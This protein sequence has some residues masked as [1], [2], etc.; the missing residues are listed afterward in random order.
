MSQAT[1]QATVSYKGYTA[2]VEW[3]DEECRFVGDSVG[4]VNTLIEVR[5]ATLEDALADFAD[6]IEW[7]IEGC[8]SEGI[9]PEKP[10]VLR[11]PDYS[12]GVPQMG[13]SPDEVRACLSAP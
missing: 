1:A 8:K 5:G 13:L 12:D 7:Y 11:Q 3:S 2:M 6:S 9:E 10:Q 4:L